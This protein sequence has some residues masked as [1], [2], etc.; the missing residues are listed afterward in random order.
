MLETTKNRLKS[1]K[2][3]LELFSVVISSGLALVV[4]SFISYYLNFD[5]FDVSNNHL[6]T[7]F[8][9]L[10][11]ININMFIITLISLMVEQDTS[12]IWI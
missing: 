9:V 5:V 11:L 4:I 7:S 2:V 12:N 3:L 10:V 8:Y 1:R 6:F